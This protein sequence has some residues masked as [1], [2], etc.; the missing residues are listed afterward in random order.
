[1][2]YEISWPEDSNELEIDLRAA[3]DDHDDTWFAIGNSNLQLRVAWFILDECGDPDAG[4]QIR[5]IDEIPNNSE[6]PD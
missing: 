3:K 4:I 1:M 6:V 2:T 5:Y